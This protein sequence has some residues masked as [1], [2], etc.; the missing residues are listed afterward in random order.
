MEKLL[1]DA[2]VL[3]GHELKLSAET[4]HVLTTFDAIR[5]AREEFGSDAV[6]CYI[7]SMARTLSD[8]LE[9]QFFCKEAGI[10]GLPVVPLFETIED[11]RS[12]TGMLESAFTHPMY[13][14]L[15]EACH[16]RHHGILAY[17]DISKDR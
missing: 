4:S 9:V 16:N 13:R 10:V 2:R 8:L 14:A 15:L 7:I 17:S 12:C 3:T 6:T 11:L 5:Q 1:G